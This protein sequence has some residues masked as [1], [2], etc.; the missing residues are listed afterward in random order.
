MKL[1]VNE[2]ITSMDNEKTIA[3]LQNKSGSAMRTY[4]DFHLLLITNE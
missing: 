4:V 3:T 2:E 1:I